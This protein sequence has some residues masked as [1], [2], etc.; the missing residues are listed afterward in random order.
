MIVGPTKLLGS[1]MRQ[2]ARPAKLL[3]AVVVLLLSGCG[4]FAHRFT[5]EDYERLEVAEVNA[6]NAIERINRLESRV[7][8]L[9]SRLAEREGRY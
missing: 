6:R 1:G 9:E 4:S 2:A 5:N 7:D 8:E 3:L